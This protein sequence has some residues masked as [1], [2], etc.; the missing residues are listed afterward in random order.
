M[1]RKYEN[2]GASIPAEEGFVIAKET[3]KKRRNPSS[4]ITNIEYDKS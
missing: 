1:Y 2:K 3:A 4:L